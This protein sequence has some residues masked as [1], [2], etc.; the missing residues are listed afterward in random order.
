M[1]NSIFLP[2]ILFGYCYSES[3]LESFTETKMIKGKSL[4]FVGKKDFTLE[5]TKIIFN[6]REDDH[7]IVIIDNY[8]PL[9]WYIHVIQIYM[10]RLLNQSERE[11]R[12]IFKRVN[13]TVP[14]NYDCL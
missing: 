5:C 9:S 12:E 4:F 3:V 1:E 11:K 13:D 14:V 2:F 8:N 7:E 6:K 10:Q